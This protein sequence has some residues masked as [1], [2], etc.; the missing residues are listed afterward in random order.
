VVLHVGKQLVDVEVERSS[1]TTGGG[2][3]RHAAEALS[4]QDR[5][6]RHARTLGQLGPGHAGC[7]TDELQRRERRFR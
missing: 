4:R 3:V 6:D 1:Q 2:Q 5:R 7:A